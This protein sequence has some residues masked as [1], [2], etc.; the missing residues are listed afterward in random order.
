MAHDKWLMAD[1]KGMPKLP[2]QSHPVLLSR[3]VISYQSSAIFV[4]A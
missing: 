4:S 3:S 1:E 2:D